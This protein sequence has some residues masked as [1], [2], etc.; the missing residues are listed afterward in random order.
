MRRILTGFAL[1]VLLVLTACSNDETRDT[2]VRDALTA[3]AKSILSPGKS[4][5]PVAAKPAAGPDRAALT[6]G[7]G[8]V[9]VVQVPSRKAQ[10]SLGM[11]RQNGITR[12]YLAADGISLMIQNGILAG[13]RGFG[14]D[15]MS[16]DHADVLANLAQ[17]SGSHTRV[18]RHLDHQDQLAKT[19]L[20]CTVTSQGAQPV[21]ILGVTHKTDFVVEACTGGTKPLNNIYWIQGDTIWRS[22]QWVSDNV[23]PIII[24]QV[25]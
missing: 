2:S 14:D 13:T 22:G 19:T 1:P 11:V 21:E 4:A 20:S 5:P 25:Q 10:A 17:G 15:L 6:A 16:S 7:G 18:L 3:R 9:I 12:T 23:G 24:D 8:P